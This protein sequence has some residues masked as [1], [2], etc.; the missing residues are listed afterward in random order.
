MSSKKYEVKSQL[1]AEVFK[2]P[3]PIKP[4]AFR[5]LFP[6]TKS[7][8]KQNSNSAPKEKSKSDIIQLKI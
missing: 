3:T 7:T 1:E 2:G 4:K 8:G 5:C 6:K